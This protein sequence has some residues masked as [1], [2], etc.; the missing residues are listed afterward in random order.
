MTSIIEAISDNGLRSTNLV[1]MEAGVVVFAMHT[2][3]NFLLQDTRLNNTKAFTESH[4]VCTS[5]L[6][7]SLFCANNCWF[8]A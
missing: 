1:H 6:C 5:L 2:A 8:L 7:G 4:S 3:H